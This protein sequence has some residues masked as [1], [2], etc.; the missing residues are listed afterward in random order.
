M[1]K[2]NLFTKMIALALIMLIPI[3]TLYFYSNRISTN[4]ISEE[5]TNS[6]TNQLRFFK[7]EVDAS[8]NAIELWPDLLIHDPDISSLRDIFTYMPELDLKTTTLIRRIQ[9]KLW[10]QENSLKWRNSLHIYSPMLLREISSDGV[11]TYDP[12][13]LKDRLGPGWVF[14]NTG[15]EEQPQHTF[16]RFA[17]APYASY[18]GAGNQNLIIEIRFH[19]SNI[20][21]M[22]DQFKSGGRSDPFYY[23]P[24]GGT[25]YNRSAN[26]ELIGQVINAL[27]G[28]T[29]GEQE[30]LNVQIENQDYLVNLEKSNVIGWYLID[31]IPI[32]EIIRPIEQANYLFYISVAGLLLLGCIGAYLLYAQVQVPIKRLVVGF[33]R[34]KYGDY[35]VRM[36][37]KDSSEFGFLYTR[38]NLMV[39]Q[40]QEL[41]ETVYLERI[42]VR[43]ARL[44]QLQSQI[45]PHFFYNCFSFISSMAKLE[46]HQAVVA[47]SHHLSIYYRY[48]TRQER[49]LVALSEEVHFVTS[50]LEIQKMR[51]PRL[52]FHMNIPPEML[53]LEVPPL[54]LQPLV[55]NAV[56]HGIESSASSSMVCITGAWTSAEATLTV[57]DDGKGMTSDALQ[58]LQYRMNRHMEK[59]MGCGLWNVHHRMLLRYRH[60]AGLTLESSPLG[61]VRVTITWQPIPPGEESKT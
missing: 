9:T 23:L 54:I 49:E 21:D 32:T 57:E 2:V 7:N 61:G 34:L 53:Q 47:M 56:L 4:L 1:P 3:L 36:T 39:T 12:K 60:S 44:K 30:R 15:T 51:M 46:Q 58:A 27:Q 50:Y 29:L 45:N 35:S 6:N 42:H 37:P 16:S 19:E 28:R 38:F 18:E 26:R 17:V 59:E 22:L 20:L 11:S 8:I 5:L 13:E 41:F 40:I 52:Q 10:I 31:F 33:Q 24:E 25:F 48:T 43:E 14:L 55:E